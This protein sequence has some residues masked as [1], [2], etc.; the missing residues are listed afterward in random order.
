M[1][2][3]VFGTIFLIAL[4]IGIL[5]LKFSNDTEQAITTIAISAIL[6]VVL[7]MFCATEII[8]P[9]KIGVQVRFGKM[10]NENL[11]EGFH[12]KNVFTSV[13]TMNGKLR[14][15]T[16]TAT[17]RTSDNLDITMDL[18]LWVHLDIEKAQNVYREMNNNDV[19][20]LEKVIQPAIRSTLR[21]KAASYAWVDI[22]GNARDEYKESIF[23][24]ASELMGSKGFI[25]EKVMLRNVS[26][27]ASIKTAVEDKMKAQQQVEQMEYQ[28]DIEK[29]KAQ[30]KEIEAKG[31]AKAQDIIQRK[32]T[33]LYVQWHAINKYGELAESQNTTFVI[34]PTSPNAS[35]MPLIL[36][37]AK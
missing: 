36:G 26:P 19:T 28:I 7:T 20:H 4:A 31:I 25:L 3:I 32:L 12:I 1:G 37:G 15:I 5:M 9:G 8:P 17:V 6:F 24:E 10:L 34:M 27:P 30:I 14:E 16:E 33:P 11:G 21:E 29:K 13:N 2:Y 35:G 22:Y 23:K 18:T